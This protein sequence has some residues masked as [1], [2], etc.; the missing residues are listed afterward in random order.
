MSA[1]ASALVRAPDPRSLTNRVLTVKNPWAMFI[2]LGWKRIENRDWAPPPAMLGRRI[3]I[4]AGAAAMTKGDKEDLHDLIVEDLGDD[5]TAHARRL[6]LPKTLRE[7]FDLWDA[8][9]GRVVA[10]VT[11]AAIHQ[12]EETLPEDQR[13]W[14]VGSKG[15]EMTK[16][17]R[18]TSDPIKGQLGLWTPPSAFRTRPLSPIETPPR[19]SPPSVGRDGESP[20]ADS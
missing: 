2:A 14:W 4:H 7:W 5:Y 16:C 19:T 20:E 6:G 17:L 15:W 12:A 11:L 8:T 3:G 9:R 10:F 1:I 18:V 13:V